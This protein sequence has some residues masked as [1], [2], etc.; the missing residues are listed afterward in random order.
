[1]KR[2]TLFVAV[3]F[4]FA[5]SLCALS[6]VVQPNSQQC[7]FEE[8]KEK[9]SI[10]FEFQVTDGGMLDIDVQVEGPDSRVLYE[11]ER[12]SDGKYTFVSYKEGDYRFCFVN[13]ISTITD[14]I[15]SFKI[16]KLD[17]RDSSTM[18]KGH[19]K[20]MEESIDRIADSLNRIA[21]EQTYLKTRERAHRGTAE[22]TNLRVLWWSLFE[23]AL[24][25]LMSILQ[26]LY[27]HKLF[28]VKR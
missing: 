9:E 4:V 15:V 22:S 17:H 8:L 16:S 13:T 5:S 20:P 21:T 10:D 12:E 2:S 24:L 23:V 6:V 27:L 28:E 18:K 1:M 26:V 7:F 25:V 14:K 11:G 3:C 19:L